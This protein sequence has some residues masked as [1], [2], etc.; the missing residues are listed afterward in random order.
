MSFQW[1][2]AKQFPDSDPVGDDRGQHGTATAGG[3]FDGLAVGYAK[4][5][6]VVGMDLD[7]TARG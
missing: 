1:K 3:D 2:G 7:E 5:G 4:P 6:G